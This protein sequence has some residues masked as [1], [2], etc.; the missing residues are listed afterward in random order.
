MFDFERLDVYKKSKSFNQQ[1]Q[2][3]LKQANVDNTTKHQLRRAS[4][5]IVLNI[6]EG[7]GRNSKPDKRHFLIISRG[8]VFEC[9]AVLDL[10][11][12]ANLITEILFKD[13]YS[14]AE[15]LSKMLYAM[16]RSLE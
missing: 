14:K 3:L 12:D 8:S 10:M 5:S 15:E 4:L 9:V 16:M 7:S 2:Q 6:A 13:F 1:I 11:K